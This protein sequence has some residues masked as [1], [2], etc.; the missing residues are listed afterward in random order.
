[1]I[2]RYAAGFDRMLG[3]LPEHLQEETRKLIT[4]FLERFAGKEFPQGMRVHKCGPFISL[5]IDL[6]YRIYLRPIPGGL[7]FVFVGNH[8]DADRYL[9]KI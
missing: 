7:F 1:M 4:V 3:G 9:K 2:V 6:D 8:R 5:S